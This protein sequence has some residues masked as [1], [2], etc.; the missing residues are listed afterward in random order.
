ME[1]KFDD[2][3]NKENLFPKFGYLEL[4]LKSHNQPYNNKS[5]TME[6]YLICLHRI[7]FGAQVNLN[8]EYV[9]K[10]ENF[11]KIMIRNSI[12]L[13]QDSILFRTLSYFIRKGFDLFISVLKSDKVTSKKKLN[14]LLLEVLDTAKIEDDFNINKGEIEKALNIAE[15]KK[16]M[17]NVKFKNKIMCFVLLFFRKFIQENDKIILGDLKDILTENNISNFYEKY[18]KEITKKNKQEDAKISEE[19]DK[20]E[21]KDDLLENKDMEQK[22]E[23]SPNKEKEMTETGLSEDSSKVNAN[24]AQELLNN[25]SNDND[26][27]PL[28]NEDM[29]DI[30]GKLTKEI[31]DLKAYKLASNKEIEELKTKVGNI[32][33]LQESV[34]ALEKKTELLDKKLSL[35]LLINNL[36]AQRDSYKKSLEVILKH[37]IKDFNL[38]IEKK[39]DK[40]ESLENVFTCLLFCKDYSNCL[41]HGKGKF[42]ETINK[43]YSDHKEKTPFIAVACYKNMKDVLNC[44]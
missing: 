18:D 10:T 6:Q 11:F 29:R 35:S 13:E 1:P 31:E 15:F 28:N 3:L 23:I 42:S 34:K 5:M 26:K 37:V 30:V 22:N 16:A 43:Y 44:E 24:L 32:G 39:D 27:K 21:I 19:I 17:S 40:F 41:V 20:N 38:M 12:R 8:E 14:Q 36:N 25:N 33:P 9:Q 4:I 2:T 7:V